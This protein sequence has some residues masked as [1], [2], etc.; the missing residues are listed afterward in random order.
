MSTVEVHVKVGGARARP[1]QLKN[2]SR[3][4]G[5][6]LKANAQHAH[7]LSQKQNAI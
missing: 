6:T 3:R 1:R 2:Q 7:Q 4:N 5:D